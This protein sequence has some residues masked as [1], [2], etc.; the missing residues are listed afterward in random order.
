M[1]SENIRRDDEQEWETLYPESAIRA[2]VTE[3]AQEISEV[4]RGKRLLVVCVLRGAF[5]FTADILRELNDQLADVEVDFIAISS[6]GE[7]EVSSRAPRI[8]KDLNTNIEDREVLVVEDI[9]DTGYSFE[10]LLNLLS[11][12]NPKSLRTCALLSKPSRREVEV[13]IDFLGFSIEDRWVEGY[14]LDS[15]QRG[16]GRKNLIAK[17]Q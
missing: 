13:Q 17:R 7:G 15:N 2:R 10:K 1:T 4:Y 6:Y 8:E 11:A 12:R 14:G 9:V 16:R 3:S 5:V